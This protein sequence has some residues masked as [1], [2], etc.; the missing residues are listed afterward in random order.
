M[1]SDLAIK[2]FSFLVISNEF[3]LAALHFS[4]HRYYTYV[5]STPLLTFDV[6]KTT[7]LGDIVTF[8]SHF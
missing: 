8:F 7:P 4:I 6:Q 2:N 5:G 3:G 1:G